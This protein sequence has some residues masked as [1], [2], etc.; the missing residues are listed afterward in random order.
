[1][2]NGDKYQLT[3][4]D[5]NIIKPINAAIFYATRFEK[6]DD[7]KGPF[8]VWVKF[9]EEKEQKKEEQR[10]KIEAEIKEN[11]QKKEEKRKKIEQEDKKRKRKEVIITI[12]KWAVPITVALLIFLKLK[13]KK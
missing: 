10:K 1:M 8:N 7:K 3:K 13:N 2:K 6:K 4:K 5:S 9:Q 11:E 12:V